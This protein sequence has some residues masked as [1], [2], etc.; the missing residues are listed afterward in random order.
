MGHI[1]HV[2]DDEG[3]AVAFRLAAASAKP[4]GE[5]HCVQDGEQ[6]LEYLSNND[7]P[8][9]MFLDLELLG[10]TGGRCCTQF[11]LTLD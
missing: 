6:A 7:L 1:L 2:E 8:D 5:F 3:A 10:S 11:V 4:D 9:V